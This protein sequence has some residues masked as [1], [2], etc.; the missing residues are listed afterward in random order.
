MCC[1][2]CVFCF[3]QIITLWLSCITRITHRLQEI[4]NN[5]WYR[6]ALMTLERF[7]RWPN[8]TTGRL[9]LVDTTPIQIRCETRPGNQMYLET[10]V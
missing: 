9:N 6:I 7:A 5:L 10:V 2:I 3:C 4:L 1:N 8:Y